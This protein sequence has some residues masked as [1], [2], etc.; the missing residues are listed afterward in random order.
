[1]TSNSSTII[2]SGEVNRRIPLPHAGEILREEF[3]EPM[4]L[5]VY[6]LA[7]A[8]GVPRSR[9]NAI[10]R[11]EQGITAAI[12]LRLGKYFDVD[13]RWFMNLQTQ[14]DLQVQAERLADKIAAIPS[15]RVA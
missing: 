3:L 1:M 13:P 6:A 15:R 2:E 8:L 14:Y 7:K 12:A 5:T 4:D 11:G 10:C 9:L